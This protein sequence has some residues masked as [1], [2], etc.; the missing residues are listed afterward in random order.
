MSGAAD[1]ERTYWGVGSSRALRGHWALQELALPYRTE[2]IRTRTPD[3]ERPEF[4]AVTPRKKIPVL[5]DGELVLTESPAIVTYLAERYGNAETLYMP[6]DP[7]E[8]A[9]YYEWMS[10]ISM[11][12]DA[13][14]LYVLRRH[15][16]LPAIYGDAPNAIQACREYFVRMIEAATQSLEP[17]ATYLLGNQFTG[18]DILM[19]SCLDWAL[20]YEVSVPETF[21]AYRER[22]VVRPSYAK[23]L[24]ANA[25][26]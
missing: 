15:Q 11:E 12:L 5:Q 3:T 18:V 8:R 14:T 16:Y 26:P 20:R 25:P 24:A 22:V 1:I 21:L 7:E 13:T 10:F 17:S 6:S 23:A 4:I 19:M 9:R 2:S